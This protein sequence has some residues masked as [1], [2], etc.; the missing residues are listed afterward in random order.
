MEKE[1]DTHGRLRCGQ[2]HC[3]L[4]AGPDCSALEEGSVCKLALASALDGY[5]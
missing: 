4:W 3:S 5:L 1:K 2:C